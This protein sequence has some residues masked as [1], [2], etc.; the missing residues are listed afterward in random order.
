MIIYI[1]L[2]VITLFALY[3]IHYYTGLDI[4]ECIVIEYALFLIAFMIG[5]LIV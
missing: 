1:I 3:T 2:T 5:G 4:I